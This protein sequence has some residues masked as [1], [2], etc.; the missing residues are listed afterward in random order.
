[1]IL[2]PRCAAKGTKYRG[3][4]FCC[5]EDVDSIMYP[6]GS[7]GLF[8]FILR[9]FSPTKY[10]CGSVW[11]PRTQTGM[12][13]AGMLCAVLSILGL[14]V[15]SFGSDALFPFPF[16]IPT[17]ICCLQSLN[18]ASASTQLAPTPPWPE[19][20]TEDKTKAKTARMF[21]DC[22][23]LRRLYCHKLAFKP[24]LH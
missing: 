12:I 1:M 7:G 5:R 23:F 9:L 17:V 6:G 13:D 14:L 21:P 10:S 19:E 11:H 16:W 22:L 3:T 8:Y 18:T 2:Y 20:T 4:L 24:H 15:V